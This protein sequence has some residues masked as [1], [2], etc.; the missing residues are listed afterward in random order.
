MGSGDEA[1][2]GLNDAVCAGSDDQDEKRRAEKIEEYSREMDEVKKEMRIAAYNSYSTGEPINEKLAG[3]C[4]RINALM[5]K[6]NE[7][8]SKQKSGE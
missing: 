7:L 2:E 8:G 6:M 4:E 3:Y 1:K 5:K